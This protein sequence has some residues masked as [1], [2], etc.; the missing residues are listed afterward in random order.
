M[1]YQHIRK[2]KV[3]KTIINDL[4]FNNACMNEDA[5]SE[6]DNVPHKLAGVYDY[7]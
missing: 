3:A 2:D 7:D 4:R 1:I 6:D 5:E